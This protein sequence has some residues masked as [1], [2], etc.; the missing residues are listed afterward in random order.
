MNKIALR[1]L[2]VFLCHASG[3]K[4]P[5]REL[6]KRLVFEGVDAWLDQEKLLPGQDWRVE[7]PRAV[8]GADVVIV[9]LSQ[10]SVTKEGYVQKEIKFALDIAEE[11]PDGTIFLIPAR[12]EDCPVPERLTRWHWVDLYEENGYLKLLRSLKLRAEKVGAM[13]AQ[14]PYED[15][16]KEREHKF[17]QYYTEGLAAFYTE[18]WDKACRR[19]QSILSEQPNHKHAAEKLKEAEHQRDLSKLYS[20]SLGE[21]QAE[22]WQAAI[23]SLEELLK[24]SVEYRDAAQL[25]KNSKKQ[26]QI[27]ELYAEAQRLHAAGKWQAVLKVFEQIVA[28][29]P[30]HPDP[31]GILPSAQKEMAELKR[32]D[33]LNDLYSRAVREMDLGKWLEARGLLEQVHKTQT[34]FLETERLLKKVENE[35]IKIEDIDRRKNQVNTLYEQAHGLIRSKKWRKA[36]D[37]LEEIR[38]LDEQFIDRDGIFTKAKEELEHEDKETQRQNELAAKYA[39]AVRLL[40]EEKYQEALDKWQEVKAVDSKYPDRQWVQRTAKKRLAGEAKPKPY[41]PIARLSSVKTLGVILFFSLLGISLVA[42][43]KNTAD[44]PPSM[45]DNFNSIFYNGSFNHNKWTAGYPNTEDKIYQEGG[46]LVLVQPEANTLQFVKIGGLDYSTT[47]TTVIQADLMIDSI[48]SNGSIELQILTTVRSFLCG[49]QNSNLSIK[50]CFYENHYGGSATPINTISAQNG[51][52][53][54]FRVEIN[55]PSNSVFIYIDGEKIGSTSLKTNEQLTEVRINIWNDN[56]NNPIK[57][58]VDNVI[59]ET[60]DPP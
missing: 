47:K 52:W 1:P 25:L 45:R 49:L 8:E 11:K 35:I 59:I 42:L 43:S 34:G 15:E 9:C 10:R 30:A 31:D 26:K 36:L 40:Q 14:T 5:V 16:D 57:G 50:N 60:R 32:I 29:E 17:D 55:I 24:K 37:K 46:R 28:I 21:Y 27:K 18:D 4:P 20:Q 22:D 54:T 12:L 38:A 23:K 7:I 56:S 19:F 58:Y 3:D 44:S 6:Y 41:F 33:D 51:T 2:K 53:Y 13:V 48:E 39:E